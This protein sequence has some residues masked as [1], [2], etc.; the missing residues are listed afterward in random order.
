MSLR[1]T[2]VSDM[3]SAMKARE[4]DKVSTLRMVQSSLKNKEIELRPNELTE[5]GVQSVLKKL[6]KQRKDS[7]E[8]YQNAGRQD[9]ADKEQAELNVIEHYLPEQ[10]GEEQVVKFVEEAIAETGAT[11]MKDMGKLMQAVMAKTQGAADNK[12]I[13]QIVKSKLS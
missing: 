13:S 3:K 2:I 9:L 11:S 8:Q 4:M 10:M 1:E 12:L 5:K 6:V 7:I